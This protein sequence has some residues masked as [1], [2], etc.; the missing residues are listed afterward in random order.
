VLDLW[1]GHLASGRLAR[2]TWPS[3]VDRPPAVGRA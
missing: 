1:L 3:L 2:R